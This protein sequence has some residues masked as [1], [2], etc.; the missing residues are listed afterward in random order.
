MLLPPRLELLWRCEGRALW[1]AAGTVL[2]EAPGGCLEARDA[3]SGSLRWRVPSLR[4]ERGSRGAE[5]RA[6]ALPWAVA[7]WG[8]VEAVAHYAAPLERRRVGRYH[9]GR[10]RTTEPDVVG[11]GPTTVA[12]AVQVALP[13]GASWADPRPP[14]VAV[15]RAETG[16][17]LAGGELCLEAWEDDLLS[18]SLDLLAPQLALRWRDEAQDWAVYWVGGDQG[19]PPWLGPA[20]WSPGRE[21][22]FPP[23]PPPAGA[24]AAQGAEAFALATTAGPLWVR[25][26]PPGL[27]LGGSPPPPSTDSGP[28][29]ALAGLWALRAPWEEDLAAE[30]TGQVLLAGGRVFLQRGD[31]ILCALGSAA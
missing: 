12:L 29:E 27:G 5:E 22:P 1:I 6:L 28:A 21:D 19:V 16:E 4:E 24:S 2:L 18:L 26:A 8:A 17:A 20:R 31:G 14:R 30:G 9:P 13:G 7:P 11:R 15:E 3:R 23:A 25:R 10:G